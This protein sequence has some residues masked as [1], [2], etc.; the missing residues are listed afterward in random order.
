VTSFEE[1]KALAA[2]THDMALRIFETAN[3]PV[4]IKGFADEKVLAL[5]LL[6]RA[7]SNMKGTLLLLDAKRIVEARIIARSCLENFYWAV[8]LAEEDEAFVRKMRDDEMSHRRAQGQSI[9]NDVELEETVKQRLQAFMRAS[10]KKFGDAKTLSPKQVARIREDFQRTYIFYGHLS[11]DAHPS[12]TTLNRYAVLD[13]ADEI[14]GIDVEPVIKDAEVAETL[15]FLC[16]AAVGVCMGVNQ[17]LGGTDG[18]EALDR[19]ATRYTD[20]S[21]RTKAQ[22]AAWR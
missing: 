6:A 20:L 3:V 11:A 8:G 12:V 22:N 1:W 4:T 14:G 17:M 9:C 5:M 10:G 21:N 16:M 2:D 13:T 18:A 15:E 7:V 19:I